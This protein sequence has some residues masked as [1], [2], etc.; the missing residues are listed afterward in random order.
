MTLA[1]LTFVLVAAATL[2]T[3]LPAA[4]APTVLLLWDVKGPQTASLERT[5]TDSGIKVVYSDT[6]ES[7]WDGTNPSLKGIDVVVHLN[8]TTWQT[9]MPV[10]GQNAL[11]GF[12][13]AGGGYIHHEWNAYQLSVGQMQA[14][15]EITL[16]DRT[17]GYA[18]EIT[19]TRY[20]TQ[21]V[22][23]VTWEVPPSFSM[24]GSCNIGSIH[25]FEQ[26]PSIVLARD[27][28]GND[29]IAA[30]ELGMGRV[31]GFHHGG[32]WQWTTGLPLD[33][34]DARR[35]FADAVNWAHGCGSYFRKG[36]REAVCKKIESIR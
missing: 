5:L 26:N 6:N 27:Q 30:R 22:H 2:L 12:V 15:R 29:A 34:Q 36:P 25:K 7:G 8:G 13:K 4:A 23:P 28:S 14:M 21:G 17:S 11:V 20:E 16:F 3:A 31:V 32:N 24:T 10:A 33:S 18:G 35:L 9:E 1:R 19:I